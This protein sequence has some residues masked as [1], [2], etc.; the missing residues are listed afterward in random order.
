MVFLLHI[1]WLLPVSQDI[2]SVAKSSPRRKAISVSPARSRSGGGRVEKSVSKVRIRIAQEHK[3]MVSFRNDMETILPFQRKGKTRRRSG[4]GWR[5]STSRS[6]SR[7]SRTGVINET[8][9]NYKSCLRLRE[10]GVKITQPR[11]FFK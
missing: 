8:L 5:S 9:P 6:T 4:S 2:S 10:T 3:K 1:L 7:G 11:T